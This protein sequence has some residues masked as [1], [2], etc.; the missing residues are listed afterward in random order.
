MWR[1]ELLLS[2]EMAYTLLC[3]YAAEFIAEALPI[4]WKPGLWTEREKV[5]R[6]SGLLSH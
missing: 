5:E 6:V 2:E 3:N 1:G 4:P